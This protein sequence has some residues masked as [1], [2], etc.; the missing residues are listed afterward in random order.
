MT[1]TQTRIWIAGH[2][3]GGYMPESAPYLTTTHESARDSLLW[4]LGP[5][6]GLLDFY[7]Q[8][9]KDDTLM[10]IRVLFDDDLKVAYEHFSSYVHDEYELETIQH[11][12]QCEEALAELEG[13]APGEEWDA[14]IGY[15]HYWLHETDRSANDIPPDLEGDEL[16]E[17]IEKLNEE[18]W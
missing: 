14:W 15:Y 3:M 1:Q 11:A 2:N 18:C 8:G 5:G 4:D 13:L 16:E 9:M 7:H 10:V 17:M 12:I 6:N